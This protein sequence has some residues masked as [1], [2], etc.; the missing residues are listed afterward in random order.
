MLTC[1]LPFPP[2]PW[3]LNNSQDLHN[4]HFESGLVA[5]CLKVAIDLTGPLFFDFGFP[6]LPPSFAII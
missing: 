4:H 1:S 3:I 2:W 6:F 5:H